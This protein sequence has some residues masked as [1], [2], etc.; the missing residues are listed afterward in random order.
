MQQRNERKDAAR[1]R[2]IILDTASQ[3][4]HQHG[5][6][7]VS[8]HQI[9]KSAG[10]G[11]GTLYRRYSSKA[12]LCMELLAESFGRFM[13]SIEQYFEEAEAA[14]ASVR[15]KLEGF[16]SRAIAYIAKEIEW[17]SAITPAAVCAEDRMDL[18]KSEPFVYVVGKLKGLFDE[19]V[20]NGE[21]RCPD[22]DFAAFMAATSFDVDVFF[23]LTKDR[24]LSVEQIQQKFV[25]HYLC[26]FLK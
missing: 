2:E 7:S 17:F 21:A 11:Q 10:V 4:F 24:G 18:Y 23:Y 15:E 9:A 3:L 6:E 8:M 19:A 25:S 13:N 5:I 26:M 16:I 20:R 1:H 22:T 14:G 12:E